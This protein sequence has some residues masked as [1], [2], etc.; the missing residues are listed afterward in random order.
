MFS[1]LTNNRETGLGLGIR[2]SHKGIDGRHCGLSCNS[3]LP[4]LKTSSNFDRHFT[5]TVL[6]RCEIFNIKP[7]S[8]QHR[9]EASLCTLSKSFLLRWINMDLSLLQKNQSTDKTGRW[10][11][12]GGCW[13][14]LPVSDHNRWPLQGA[15]LSKENDD[16]VSIIQVNSP[17][18]RLWHRNVCGV[19]VNQV[20]FLTVNHRGP[21][22]SRELHSTD[23]TIDT[24]W[25]DPGG[26]WACLRPVSDQE[27]IPPSGGCRWQRHTCIAIF[28]KQVVFLTVNHRGP[29]PLRELHSTDDTIVWRDPGGSWACLRPVSNYEW[30][31]PSRGRWW[32][33][34]NY[35]YL[36]SF[37]S[38]SFFL[39]WI[40]AHPSPWGN[41]TPPTTQ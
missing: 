26:S 18:Q 24:V 33:K 2:A 40:T 12:P 7:E 1:G 10:R 28:V 5:E 34:H 16:S 8:Q 3:N 20:V 30:I 4:L 17:C 29:L 39:R 11:K 25:K 27:S 23:D 31:H 21:L 38:G 13:A 19:F 14:Y 22:P 37:W 32:H 15:D 41:F 9:L 6:P 36:P 35:V